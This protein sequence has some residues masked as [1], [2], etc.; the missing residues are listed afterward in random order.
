V[1]H[2]NLLDVKFFV[3]KSRIQDNHVPVYARIGFAGTICD[4]SIKRDIDIDKWSPKIGRAKGA[5]DDVRT[6]NNYLDQV[7]ADIY[8]CLTVLR[9]KIHDNFAIT[10]ETIKNEFCGLEINQGQTLMQ[11]VSYHNTHLRSTIEP[12]TMKNYYATEK[13]LK[14]FLKKKYN[15]AVDLPLKKLKY[16]F[17][18]DFQIFLRERKPDHGQR[19][20]GHNTGMKHIERLRKIIN[21]A[22]KNEWIEKDPFIKF[23]DRLLKK[24]RVFLN[25][26][27]VNC[28]ESADLPLGRLKYVRDIFVFSLYTGLS[29][30]DALQ[31]TP[32][33]ISRGID[34]ELWITTQRQKSQQPV[35][36]PLLP[37][38]L[39]VITKY[40]NDPRSMSAGT[41]FPPLSN[42]KM[43]AGLQEVASF[44]RITKHI[45]FHIARH[46][47]ATT[48]ALSNGMPIE[49]LS[50]ILG[51][52][53]IRTTQIYAKVVEKR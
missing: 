26:E 1:S 30:C 37:K 24:D 27:E 15:N 29:Y 17:L 21:V 16:A 10:A 12:G 8:N 44:C 13:F 5:R 9:T 7:R 45:T 28:I 3:K 32:Q 40:Q 25:Q 43:N 14:E 38:A 42:Q 20:C 6:F 53:S 39:E 49:T 36:I 11:I 22:L 41:V 48:I 33:N 52:T 51:H 50:K 4:V 47:F 35:R 34:G 23:K 46:T 18:V 31:L 19:P 2:P